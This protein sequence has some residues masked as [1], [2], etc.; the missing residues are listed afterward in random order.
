MNSKSDAETVYQQINELGRQVNMPNLVGLLRAAGMGR[1][2]DLAEHLPF[3]PGDD[4]GFKPGDELGFKP[5][6]EL[7]FKPGDELS[8]LFGPPGLGLADLPA[9]AELASAVTAMAY[10]RAI[11]KDLR[12]LQAKLS[13]EERATLQKALNHLDTQVDHIESSM[14]RAVAASAPGRPG[15][16]GGSENG[17]A[18][19]VHLHLGA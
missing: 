17:R 13:G 8:R 19:H 11:V 9:L 16:G 4:L 1:R 7:G 2:M 12:L 18:V 10:A 14:K 3:K 6:D 5:G 15:S